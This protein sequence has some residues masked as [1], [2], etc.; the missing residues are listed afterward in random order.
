MKIL[1]LS[2]ILAILLS[3]TQISAATIRQREVTMNSQT[4]RWV[5]VKGM[6]EPGDTVNFLG[7]LGTGDNKAVTVWLDSPGGSAAEGLAIARVI[8]TLNLNTYVHS[9]SK[10]DSI[11][12]IMFLSGKRKMVTASSRIGVHAAHDIKTKRIDAYANAKIGWYLGS[13]D[14]PEELVDLWINTK[15]DRLVDLNDGPNTNMRLGLETV[16]PL[17]IPLLERLLSSD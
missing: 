15:P 13:I 2:L 8:K 9:N 14:Y 5:I 17:E 10:C 4:E 11:C 7:A 6:I 12:S 3:V 1:Q 16:Q